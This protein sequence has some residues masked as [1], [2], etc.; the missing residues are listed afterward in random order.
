MRV[1]INGKYVSQNQLERDWKL[2]LNWCDT[3]CLDPYNRE[4]LQ[5]FHNERLFT[6]DLGHVVIE[7]DVAYQEDGL[8]YDTRSTD[9][10]R[11]YLEEI[12]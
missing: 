8:A 7:R 4:N 10:P 1:K 11:E 5:T 6:N 9:E 12:K 2:Y 3:E